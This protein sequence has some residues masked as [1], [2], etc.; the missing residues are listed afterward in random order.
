MFLSIG[1][2]AGIVGALL[3]LMLEWPGLAL[4]APMIRGAA[5]AHVPVLIFFAALPATLGGLGAIAAPSSVGARGSALPRL[6]YVGL[7]LFAASLLALLAAIFSPGVAVIAVSVNLLAFSTVLTGASLVVTVLNRSALPYRAVP[8]GGWSWLIA[9]AFAVCAAPVAAAS[10][11]M[12]L[13]SGVTPRAA[14]DTSAWP[15]LAVI[16][17]VLLGVVTDL[18]R[19]RLKGRVI[20]LLA[21]LLGAGMLA[22]FMGWSV[23]VLDGNRTTM[24][25]PA[26]H[27]LFLLMIAPF[28]VA[29]VP[30]LG[31]VASMTREERLAALFAGGMALLL[32]LGLTLEVLG[33][34]RHE[35]I[36]LAVVFGLFAGVFRAKSRGPWR[37]IAVMLVEAQFGLL[38]AASLAVLLPVSPFL[39]SVG[40]ATAA[41]SIGVFAAG[42]LA[43][44]FGALRRS[45]AAS[46]PA[47][48][49]MAA[50]QIP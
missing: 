16:L 50:G 22:V 28:V 49:S 17:C 45:L 40:A 27:A 3:S 39:K 13:F 46:R 15:A 6:E 2:L 25:G 29:W 14:C 33:V 43:D 21:S 47:A 26:I 18:L 10:F 9:G 36:S 24:V 19:P 34:A 37:L 1:V 48:S 23:S 20:A 11:T 42:L 38:L 8:F 32:P 31:G 41:L 35:A 12:Q 4:S 7:V 44:S 5:D 30:G